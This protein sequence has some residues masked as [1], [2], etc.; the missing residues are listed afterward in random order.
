MAKYDHLWLSLPQNCQFWPTLSMCVKFEIVWHTMTKIVKHAL[1]WP[2]MDY[3]GQQCSRM[4]NYDQ[5]HQVWPIITQYIQ[6]WQTLLKNA[7]YGHV[8]HTVPSIEE[9]GLRRPLNVLY[10]WLKSSM[11]NYCQICAIIA[12]SAQLW[13]DMSGFAIRGTIH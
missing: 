5:E 9:C 7:S 10:V 12:S 11:I 6:F 2:I 1:I 3:Y 4:I 13:K 8:G